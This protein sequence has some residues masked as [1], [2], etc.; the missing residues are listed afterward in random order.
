MKELL[1]EAATKVTIRDSGRILNVTITVA[2]NITRDVAKGYAVKSLEALTDDEARY[3]DVQFY[4]VKN[5]E[6]AKEFP[7]I[8]YKIPTADHITWTRDR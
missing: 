5:N 1:P 7:I 6:E 3:Y 4:L 8:G 2:D